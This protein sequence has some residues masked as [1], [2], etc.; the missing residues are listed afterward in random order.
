MW[1]KIKKGKKGRNRKRR[2]ER[3]WLFLMEKCLR[4]SVTVT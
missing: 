1:K 3:S 4:G 2:G